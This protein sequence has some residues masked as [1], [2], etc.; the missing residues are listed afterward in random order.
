MRFGANSFYAERFSPALACLVFAAAS[1]FASAAAASPFPTDPAH[2]YSFGLFIGIDAYPA[3]TP[4][5]HSCDFDAQSM[6]NFFRDQFHV[7]QGLLLTENQATRA[8][9][10]DAL[11]D[12]VD[13]VARARAQIDA[14]PGNNKPTINVVITYSGHG[15]RVRR[16]KTEADPNGDDSAWVCWDCDAHNENWNVV[17]GYELLEIHEQLAKLGVGAHRLRLL[18]LRQ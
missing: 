1:G 14:M 4:Q 10:G 5:L 18:P 2:P 3:M 11:A 9:I 17:R 13:R 12:L 8:G 7:T 15:M 6:R 16:L